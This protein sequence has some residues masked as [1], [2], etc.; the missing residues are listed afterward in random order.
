PTFFFVLVVVNVALYAAVAL[1]L[2]RPNIT[3]LNAWFA[4]RTGKV[5]PQTEGAWLPARTRV[6]KAM[7]LISLGVAALPVAS[8]LANIVPWWRSPAPGLTL[9]AAIAVVIIVLVTLA[10][11][12][13]WRRTP[14]GPGTV[15]AGLLAAV[16]AIDVARGSPLQL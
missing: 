11:A 15:I 16:L 8:Y 1:G 4:R 14:L 9:T 5:P 6:L 10:L 3:K 13:P 2:K 7:R 12:G